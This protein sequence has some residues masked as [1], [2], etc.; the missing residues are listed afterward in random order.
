[1][2]TCLKFAMMAAAAFAVLSLATVLSTPAT[3]QDDNAAPPSTATEPT[4]RP[5]QNTA[6]RGFDRWLNAHPEEAKEI[7]KDPTLI[8]NPDF[9]GKHPAL[10]QYMN[11]HPKFKEAAAKDPGK[12]VHGSVRRGKKVIREK[13]MEKKQQ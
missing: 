11:D 10:Q 2:R 3:A 5:Q 9:M 8:N 13:H 12:V 1:M 4:P 6:W 7:R